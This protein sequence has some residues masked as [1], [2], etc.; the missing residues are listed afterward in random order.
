MA[1]VPHKKTFGMSM[2]PLLLNGDHVYFKK[3]SWDHIRV[4]D[5]VVVD[6]GNFTVTHRVVYKSDTYLITKGDA[7]KYTDGKIQKD[8]VIGKVERVKRNGTW[9]N[10]S[11]FYSLQSSQYLKLLSRIIRSFSSAKIGYIILKGLP[12]HLTYQNIIPQYLYADC[13]ILIQATDFKKAEKLLLTLGF[14][15]LAETSRYAVEKEFGYV[16]NDVPIVIDLHW[17]PFSFIGKIGLLP[18]LYPKSLYEK[19][20]RDLFDTKRIIKVGGVSYPILSK[21]H[22]VVFL[23]MHFFNHD[24]SGWHRMAF[25]D[26]VLRRELKDKRDIRAITNLIRQYRFTPFIRLALNKLIA[27]YPSK[28]ALLLRKECP[29]GA[30]VPIQKPSTIERSRPGRG[31]NKLLLFFKYSP[32]PFP[33]RLMVFLE[34]SLWLLFISNLSFFQKK[35]KRFSDNKQIKPL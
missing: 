9:F 21:E 2:Q 35:K 6:K 4:N 3:I 28:Q 7:N 33:V 17:E 22:L 14:I 26:V 16:S 31:L 30:T 27:Y 8:G 32:M 13:D 23:L 29:N 20:T 34:P 19:Y 1:I 11:Q 5:I 24:L 15:V 10:P 18:T 12:L 25:L